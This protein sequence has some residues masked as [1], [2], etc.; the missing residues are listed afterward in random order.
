MFKTLAMRYALIGA[1]I[2]GAI[3]AIV[4]ILLPHDFATGL[5]D[6]AAGGIW[7][8]IISGLGA[9]IGGGIGAGIGARADARQKN[10]D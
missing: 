7:D 5:K 9:G 6:I 4:G 1:I 2:G 8:G 3:S 10:K